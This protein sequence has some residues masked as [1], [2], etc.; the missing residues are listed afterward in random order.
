M[1]KILDEKIPMYYMWQ[2]ICHFYITS[3]PWD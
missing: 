1:I 3:R 2:G